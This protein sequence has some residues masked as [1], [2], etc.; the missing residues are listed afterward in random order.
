MFLRFMQR[1]ANLSAHQDNARG[2]HDGRSLLPGGKSRGLGPVGVNA[3]KLL[4]VAIVHGH[5]PV[6]M[7]AALVIAE[8]L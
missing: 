1:P 8:I 7:L 5:L 4:A 3:G 6:S 2:L